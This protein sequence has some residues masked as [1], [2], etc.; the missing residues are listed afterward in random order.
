MGAS[1]FRRRR[2]VP[3]AL[4]GAAAVLA[5]CGVA[6]EP[7]RKQAPPPSVVAV[8]PSP[9]TRTAGPHTQVSMR[10]IAP[11]RL[12]GLVVHGSR[13][14]RHAGR[15][16]PHADGR[17]ASF[18][19]LRPFARGERV[20][21]RAPARVAGTAGHVGTFS[22]ARTA[23]PARAPAAEA[24]PRPRGAAR[25]RS[26]PDLR[27][28]AIDVRRNRVP[29]AA[30]DF[31]VAPKAGSTQAGPM[32]VDGAGRLVWFHRLPQGLQ[33]Y[34]F[35]A[36]SFHGRPVLTW[37]QGRFLGAFG[38]GEGVIYD[39]ALRRITRVRAGN[40]YQSDL[41]EF[42]LTPRN[43]ALLTIYNPVQRSLS[44]VSGPAR[45]TV[46]EG[47]VQEV[48]VA[49]GAVLFEWHSL[50]EVPLSDS[51]MEVPRSTRGN[52]WDYFHVNSVDLD[53]DGNFLISGRHTHAVYK[54]DRA[55]GRIL[56]RLGGKRSDFLMGPGTRFL[57][58]HDAR[59]RA[60]GAITI[61]DNRARRP[62]PRI[63]SRVLALRVDEAARTAVLIS[64]IRHPG[65]V[66]GASQ[67]N[68]QTL[69]DGSVVV[70]WGGRNPLFSQFDAQGRLR[71]DARFRDP[72]AESYRAYRLPWS[73]APPSRP[74]LAARARGSG[75]VVYA[76]WNGATGVA[77][78]RVVTPGGAAPRVLARTSRTGFET[79]IRVSRRTARVAV[80]A[81]GPNGRVLATS[82]AVA[83]RGGSG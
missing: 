21:V 66:L 24:P 79:A 12:R 30:G 57:W 53:A 32:I 27:P 64:Q 22:I 77:A 52:P 68:A 58:Q 13:S 75:M 38:A 67:G 10:G 74:A 41:H 83:V 15:L 65:R 26:R 50:R 61:F 29:A 2:A 6:R 76:S 56:W 1:P 36:Q 5:A 33:A 14:G 48:D 62:A 18:V 59:R 8:F 51:Y 70:G 11:E 47:V 43:T 35:R 81:L 17:G 80:Q 82:R 72:D 28:P 9:G 31:F 25:F 46:V 55:T 44:S 60:D 19:P 54:V 7:T 4:L 20:S 78:W 45:G 37:W 16:V 63:R 73:A 69:P 34:D 49:T 39:S 23:A 3:I 40:G 71:F 42:K